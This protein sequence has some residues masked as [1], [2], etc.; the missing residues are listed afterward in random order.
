MAIVGERVG[1]IMPPFDSVSH[2]SAAMGIGNSHH[3]LDDEA[4]L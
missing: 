2:W 4:A 1:A 3:L